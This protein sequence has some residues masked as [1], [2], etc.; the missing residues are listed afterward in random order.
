MSDMRTN[1]QKKARNDLV[2]S[3]LAVRRAIG[4]LGFVMPLT[5]IIYG[6]ASTSGLQNSISAYYYTPMREIFVGI[7]CAQAVFLWSYEGYRPETPGIITDRNVARVAALGS[8]GVALAP[9]ARKE[10]LLES[11]GQLPGCTLTQCL[12]GSQVT[13]VIH[14]VSAII[15]LSA[16]AVFSLVLF[17]KGGSDTAEKRARQHIYRIC[18]WVIVGTMVMIALLVLS[19]LDDIFVTLKPVFWLEAIASFAFAVSW[20]VKGRSLQLLVR[21]MTP[22]TG[23][24]S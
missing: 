15:F 7:F 10:N 21:R 6:L 23:K 1:Q 20:S 22:E 11:A 13:S 2:L 14:Y 17:V 24:G 5:L 18:G 4:C 3:F 16:L 8:L 12:L 9:M 19:G